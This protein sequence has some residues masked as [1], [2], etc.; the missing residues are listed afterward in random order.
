MPCFI[1]GV[2]RKIQCIYNVLQNIKRAVDFGH[3]ERSVK[4]IISALCGRI[5]KRVRKN[6]VRARSGEA[7]YV[8][9][10]VSCL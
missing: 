7:A 9:P 2:L 4:F 6:K 8:C 1:I 5:V 3:L 10:H